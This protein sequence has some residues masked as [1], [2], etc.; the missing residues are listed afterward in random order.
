VQAEISRQ[1]KLMV[2][3][4]HQRGEIILARYKNEYFRSINAD[5]KSFEL[6]PSQ[7]FQTERILTENLVDERYELPVRMK[8][9]V[10]N[11]EASTTLDIMVL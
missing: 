3:I 11:L 10:C 7:G 4:M 2:W 1:N 5:E 8:N 9:N 6:K